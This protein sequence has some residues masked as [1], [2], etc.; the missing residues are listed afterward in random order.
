MKW[1]VWNVEISLTENWNEQYKLVFPQDE[2]INWFNWLKIYWNINMMG[3]IGISTWLPKRKKSTK[4][5]QLHS[6]SFYPIKSIS[7]VKIKKKTSKCS[8]CFVHLWNDFQKSTKLTCEYTYIHTLI[9]IN[10]WPMLTLTEKYHW[11]TS[12][13]VSL[14]IA[15]Y[16]IAIWSSWVNTITTY[17]SNIHLVTRLSSLLT[18]KLLLCSSAR[19]S[20]FLAFG[21]CGVLTLKQTNKQKDLRLHWKSMDHIQYQ[22]KYHTDSHILNSQYR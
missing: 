5:K 1:G 19:K 17:Y 14:H 6:A 22:Q 11:R 21:N 15:V 10:N 7:L 12:H 9:I 4:Q 3:S 13:H 8:D 20:C 18:E 16:R 2:P